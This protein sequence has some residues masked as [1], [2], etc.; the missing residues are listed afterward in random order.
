MQKEL[1][2]LRSPSRCRQLVNRPVGCD[3]RKS[4]P[5]Y[6]YKWRLPCRLRRHAKVRE[7]N[8][9]SAMHGWAGLKQM[10]PCFSREDMEI[11]GCEKK[12]HSSATTGE[13]ADGHRQQ[14]QWWRPLRSSTAGYI[15]S[16][17]P[18]D[19]RRAVILLQFTWRWRGR[20]LECVLASSSTGRRWPGGHEIEAAGRA[21]AAGRL[22]ELEAPTGW[23]S[24]PWRPWAG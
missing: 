10:M 23:A 6:T 19:S 1:L 15:N 14:L 3:M 9:R 13:T 2:K 20:E 16:S 11:G 24:S 8:Q 4:M 22:D 18:R 21:T 17:P 7:S 5:L 12:K